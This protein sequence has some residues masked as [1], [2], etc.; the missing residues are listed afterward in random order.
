MCG[1]RAAAHV[2]DFPEKRR[3]GLAEG[4]LNDLKE[5]TRGRIG[6]HDAEVF[7]LGDEALSDPGFG[8]D[9]FLRHF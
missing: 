9:I 5:H 6:H 1:F 3:E 7:V 2:F 8:R 4:P